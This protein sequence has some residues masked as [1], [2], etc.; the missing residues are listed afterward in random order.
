MSGAPPPARRAGPTLAAPAFTAASVALAGLVYFGLGPRPKARAWWE[1][2]GG[3]ARAL[4]DTS[5]APLVEDTGVALGILGVAA[6]ALAAAVFAATRSALA[7]WLAVSAGIAALSFAFYALEARF[8]WLFFRWRWTL[9]LVL[10]ALAVGAAATAPLLASSW[11]RLGW[12]ARVASYLPVLVA[13]LAVE[14]N[15]TGTNPALRFAISPWPFVQ[16]FGL[17]TVAAALGALA[18]GVGLGLAAAARAG[19][20]AAFWGLGAS[21]AAAFPAGAIGLAAW[22]ELLPVPAGARASAALAAASVAAFALAASFGRAG[23]GELAA[24]RALPI[25]LGGALV[26]APVALGQT[27]ARLDYVE[28]RDQRA[29]AIIDALERQRARTGAYPEALSE[30]VGTGELEAV[31]APRI[32]FAGLAA[33]AFGYQNFGESYLLEFSAPRWVQC[34]YSPP[35]AEDEEEEEDGGGDAGAGEWSCPSKPPELW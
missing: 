24:R 34:A 10:V 25:A 19:A 1:P 11:L 22:S 28:T 13:V 9:S 5:L 33:P 23:R 16:I 12:R 3:L 32:G 27:L 21:S 17:E 30:L 31:P 18:L 8:V 4:A 26:L 6:A 20:A 15:V 35:F 14:R 7:R 29:Q 2:S